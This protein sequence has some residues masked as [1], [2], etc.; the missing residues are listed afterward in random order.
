[1]KIT[2]ILYEKPL[3]LQIFCSL[4]MRT[5]RRLLARQDLQKNLG[6]MR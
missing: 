3:E 4:K 6:L 1:V 2:A 5:R